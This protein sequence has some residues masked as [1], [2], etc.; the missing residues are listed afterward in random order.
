MM[1]GCDE[2][3]ADLLLGLWAEMIVDSGPE[4]HIEAI[5]QIGIMDVHAGEIVDDQTFNPRE[6]PIQ[7]IAGG[8]S[9]M[10]LQH[11]H[12]MMKIDETHRFPLPT[13]NVNHKVSHG[14]C[15]QK[16]ELF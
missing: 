3:G 2:C 11:L 12:Q 4:Q 14:G 13:M 7:G 1:M 16:V 10:G 15:R 5:K 6:Y 8:K 9:P